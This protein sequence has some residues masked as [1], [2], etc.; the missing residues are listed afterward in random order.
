MSLRRV[1][2]NLQKCGSGDRDI[3]S[4]CALL[5]RRMNVLDP[6]CGMMKSLKGKDDAVKTVATRRLGL[7]QQHDVG[8]SVTLMSWIQ[9]ARKSSWNR[10]S[11]IIR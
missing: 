10:I 4:G 3:V 5:N 6:P 8:C 7:L 9:S 2:G 1:H 11:V